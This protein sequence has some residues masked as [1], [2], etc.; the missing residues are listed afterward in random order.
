[1][2]ILF[3]NSM[4]GLGGGERWLLDSAAGLLRRGHQVWVSGR[5][6]GPVLARAAQAGARTLPAPFAGDLDLATVAVLGRFQA[7]ESPDVVVAQIQR[8]HRLCA[9]AAPAGGGVPLV[10]RVGQLRR[11]PRKWFNRLAWSRLALVLA[12]CEAIRADLAHTGLV[13]AGRLRV[14]YNGLPPV[15]PHE[16][17]AARAAIGAGPGDEVV[18]CVARLAVRKGHETLLAA[19]PAVRAARP[20]ARLLLAGGGSRAAELR[21]LAGRLGLQD[22][23]SFLGEVQDVASVWAAADLSVLPSELEGLPYAVLESMAAGVPC[24]ATRVAGVPEMLEHEVSGLLVPPRDAGA[25][26]RELVRGLADGPLRARLVSGAAR[27]ARERFGYSEMLDRFE[28]WM[29][30]VADGRVRA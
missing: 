16:R 4:K 8:A 7:R 18:A 24:V 13:P 30:E 28:A 19:W 20:R 11:V 27:T 9:L 22:S 1:M 26:A 29:L 5:A 15:A 25:L 6:G 2:K 10:L 12:N 3:C 21:G 23:V 17:A 14:L